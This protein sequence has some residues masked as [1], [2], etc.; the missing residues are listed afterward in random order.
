VGSDRLQIIVCH[1][2]LVLQHGLNESFEEFVLR[3]QRS[4][5]DII[6]AS[7]RIIHE[8]AELLESERTIQGDRVRTIVDVQTDGGGTTN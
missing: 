1:Q 6:N 2:L 8:L 7:L 4:A 5:I 3:V